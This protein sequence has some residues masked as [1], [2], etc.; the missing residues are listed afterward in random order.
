MRFTWIIVGTLALFGLYTGWWVFAASQFGAKAPEMRE[1]GF[2]WE[3]FDV[4]G[5]PYRLQI[6]VGAPHYSGSGLEWQ[7]DHVTVH[8]S[9]TDLTRVI[10]NLPGVQHVN[11]FSIK[12][13]KL[14]LQVSNF[15]ATTPDLFL[16]GEGLE[17]E[18]IYAARLKV[19]TRLSPVVQRATDIAITGLGLYLAQGFGPALGDT[20]RELRLVATLEGTP[21][22][23]WDGRARV[24]E[25]IVD[26]E[27]GGSIVAA[28]VLH[29]GRDGYLSGKL[30][31][32]VSDY[33][34]LLA[35]AVQSGAMRL[36]QAN[37]ARLGLDL[38]DAQD[39]AQDSK[40][41]LPIVLEAGAAYIGPIK[42]MDLPKSFI[43]RPITPSG[44]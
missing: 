14:R 32:R 27:G 10:F 42:V 2:D 33:E 29:P 20:I 4:T 1:A 38:L 28:G 11:D 24:Q 36:D 22:K 17:V 26:L 34:I 16:D 3:S 37:V 19:N 31:A 5:Y 39:G 13:E 15:S 35:R 43:E 18:D 12:P 7:T 30:D 41:S 6:E 9:P 25:L 21:N 8:G 40:V 44:K 23:D